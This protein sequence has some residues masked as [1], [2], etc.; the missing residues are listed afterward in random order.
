M[1][2]RIGRNGRNKDYILLRNQHVQGNLHV[3]NDVLQFHTQR[4]P[5]RSKTSLLVQEIIK[6]FCTYKREWLWQSSDR[7]NS[8]SSRFL[9][10][11]L[12]NL[13]KCNGLSFSLFC[14]HLW[15]QMAGS[16]RTKVKRKIYFSQT[17]END[18]KLKKQKDEYL[19]VQKL[20]DNGQYILRGVSLC[21]EEY[22]IMRRLE[23]VPQYGKQKASI[24]RPL[25]LQL[26]E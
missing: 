1:W 10:W 21:K 16:E 25:W 4:G 7:C 13:I 3:H 18:L 23:K 9:F 17:S 12:V 22:F 2:R 20:Y 11:C 5:A 24:V 8:N 26:W 15:Q 19:D 14:Q 6:I